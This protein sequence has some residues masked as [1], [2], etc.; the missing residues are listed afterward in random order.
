VGGAKHRSA[1]SVGGVPEGTGGLELVLVDSKQGVAALAAAAP[2]AEGDADAGA[3]E[4]SALLPKA[5]GRAAG[6]RGDIGDVG[7]DE[8]GGGAGGLPNLT[9][10][11]MMSSVGF[12]C[13]FAQFGVGTGSCL[14]MLNNLGQVVVALGGR[15]GGQVVIVSLF[16]VANAA[17][18]HGG[19]GGGPLCACKAEYCRRSRAAPPSGA[20]LRRPA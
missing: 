1:S 5:G 20:A 14:A 3:D 2:A 17:G 13:L 15:R 7:S 16:S 9:S 19:G 11:Q 10:A 18:G 12:W 4:A 8:E 6:R